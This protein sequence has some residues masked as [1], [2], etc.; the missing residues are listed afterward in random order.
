MSIPVDCSLLFFFNSVDLLFFGPPDK[1]GM[2]N[3]NLKFD[4][5]QYKCYGSFSEWSSC[6]FKT[7]NPPRKQEETKLPDSVHKSPVDD[8]NS[9][10]QKL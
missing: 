4:G 3:T 2:C 5:K 9:Y 7:R 10:M 1:C 8:V 6:T